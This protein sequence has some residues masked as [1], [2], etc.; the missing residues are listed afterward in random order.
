MTD[1]EAARI[2]GLPVGA[3]VAEIEAAYARA[4]RST[5]PDRF[6]GAAPEVIATASASFVQATAAREKLLHGRTGGGKGTSAHGGTE[7]DA[8][9][10]SLGRRLFVPPYTEPPAHRGP[11]PVRVW[12]A[13]LLVAS[14][15]AAFSGAVAF[16]W[17]LAVIVPLDVATIVF[18]RGGS[19]LAMRLAI[20]FAA[21]FA[22]LTAVYGSY[23]PL[24]ILAFLLGCVIAVIVLA[25]ARTTGEIGRTTA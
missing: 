5:H 2:L 19:V 18:A 7:P 24:V 9:Y 25:R 13:M 17:S 21:V 14:V 15:L 4:A 6:A 3:S 16:P 11:W 20:F 22:V 12:I 23:I 8:Q 10:D 1:E